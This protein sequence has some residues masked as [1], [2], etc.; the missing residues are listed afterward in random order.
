MSSMVGS[1][2]GFDGVWL[3]SEPDSFGAGLETAGARRLRG[4]D[5]SGGTRSR[6]LQT[7]FVTSRKVSVPP[8]GSMLTASS[9]A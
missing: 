6:S 7:G 3:A 8:A 5:Q 9:L 4:G 1:V 2:W